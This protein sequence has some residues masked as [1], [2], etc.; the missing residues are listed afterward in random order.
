MNLLRRPK[1][2][3]ILSLAT[4]AM[5]FSVLPAQAGGVRVSAI[6]N[7]GRSVLLPFSVTCVYPDGS[8]SNYVKYSVWSGSSTTVTGCNEFTIYY[9][10]SRGTKYDY[11]M[12]S[13]LSYYFEWNG[14]HWAFYE[15]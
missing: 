2:S 6:N 3:V 4:I 5:S 12:Y 9:T 13:G 15:D 11:E 7:G 8:E 1:T 10:S 14:N